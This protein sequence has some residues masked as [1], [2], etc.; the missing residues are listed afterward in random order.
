MTGPANF[1]CGVEFWATMARGAA[2]TGRESLTQN[3]GYT[4]SM[5]EVGSNPMVA[6]RGEEVENEKM[7]QA[8]GRSPAHTRPWTPCRTCAEGPYGSDAQQDH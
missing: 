1:G 8:R 2:E 4:P 5:G 3:L 6:R 7:V